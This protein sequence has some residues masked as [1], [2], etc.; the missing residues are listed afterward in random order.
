[1]LFNS[2]EYLI[3]FP[4]V[5]ALYFALPYRWRWAFLLA[6]SYYFYM[7][8]RVEYIFLIIASTL[9]NYYASIIMGRCSKKSSKV[10]YLVFSLII[11]LGLLFFFKY[12]NFFSENVN[13]VFSHFNIF[14]NLPEFNLLLP[15]GISF[16]T[17]Q[18]IGY[19]VDVYKGKTDPETH[20]GKFALYVS[21][22]PQ[23]VAGPIERSTRLLPQFYKKM[24]FDSQR[25]TSGL[26]LILW[27]F[28]KKVVVADRLGI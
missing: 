7:C 5:V 16:Y 15:V 8:W 12:Y 11:N 27:G 1:M 21:F 4:L 2:F 25:V 18:T 20:L 26:R 22:F 9:V 17:F 10:K 24:D 19:A 14:Y 28:F 6:A 23:L 13:E 3:F